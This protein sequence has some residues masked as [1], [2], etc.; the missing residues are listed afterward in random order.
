MQEKTKKI[1]DI[2][3]K[4]NTFPPEVLARLSKFVKEAT[5]QGAYHIHMFSLST[6]YL[7]NCI[8]FF[9]PKASDLSENVN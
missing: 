7:H 2:W 6:F 3:V 9:R 1:V 4:S 8:N 5:E